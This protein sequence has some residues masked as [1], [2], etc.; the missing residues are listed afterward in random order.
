MIRAAL[1]L[2]AG[3]AA[4][5]TA[6]AQRT[7]EVVESAGEFTLNHIDLPADGTGSLALKPCTSCETTFHRVT[8]ATRYVVNGS[9]LA[10]VDFAIVV[11]D[12]RAANAEQRALVGLFVD[13]ASQNVT[14]VLLFNPLR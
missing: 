1:V 4:L 12:I 6:Q 2:I 7:L 9:E 10:F 14:R 8:P 5:T 3:L 13:R 11:E